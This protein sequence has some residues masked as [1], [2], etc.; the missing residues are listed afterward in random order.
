[1]TDNLN[2]SNNTICAVTDYSNNPNNPDADDFNFSEII[3]KRI[4]KYNNIYPKQT[5]IKII[6]KEVDIGPEM[7]R[8]IINQQ[9]P[10]KKRDLIIVIGIILKMK[11]KTINKALYAYNK[12][13]K[14][15]KSDSR[16]R[17]FIG[18]F[19]QF[20]TDEAFNVSYS[21]EKIN[22]RL[23]RNK[24]EPLDLHD[25]RKKSSQN[26]S[27]PHVL[28][29][30]ILELKVYTPLA[31]DLFYDEYNSL[32]SMY[33]PGKYNCKGKMILKNS[34]TG[35]QIRLNI[36]PFNK[37]TSE[38]LNS[39]EKP[40]CYENIQVSGEYSDFF[41]TL[42]N[43]IYTEKNKFISLLNDT[44]NYINRASARFQDYSIIVFAEEYNY[45]IPEL[46]EYFLCLYTN[47]QYEFHVY[48]TS[49]FMY[50][51]LTPEEYTTIYGDTIPQP[52]KTYNIEQI[53]AMLSSN[54]N[55]DDK[56][57]Y[58]ILKK[59]FLKLQASVSDL[60]KRLKEGKVFIRNIDYIYDNP[61]KAIQFFNVTND[62]N[63]TYDKEH[64][65]NIQCNNTATFSA[66]EK[67]LTIEITTTDIID[68]F[69]LGL[70]S[71]EDIIIVKQRYGS[72]NAL[73]K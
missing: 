32:C 45:S 6:A 3:K 18:I 2:T 8:K 69:K 23:M 9:K 58:T 46:N 30:E 5:S 40:T 24:L 16:D 49:A 25:Y 15:N 41:I 61:L 38:K 10:T 26:D 59:A 43:S 13:A 12:M 53:D 7:F 73:I 37:P 44:R 47:G 55:L 65:E 27:I 35:E 36:S 19:Y 56:I 66:K 70:N 67:N 29:Y 60:Y 21:I 31:T 50:F 11:L 64:D 54:T 62:F 22:L 4:K 28:P 17:F 63:Y 34:Q 72:I 33:D 68:A 48:N 51:Y 20:E 42:N 39:N 14:L 1:M 71:I 57:Q 52:L